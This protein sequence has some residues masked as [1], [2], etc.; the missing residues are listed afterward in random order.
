[1]ILAAIFWVAMIG[2][3]CGIAAVSPRAVPPVIATGAFIVTLATLGVAA[4]R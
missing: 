4:I 1:V 2:G 3:I